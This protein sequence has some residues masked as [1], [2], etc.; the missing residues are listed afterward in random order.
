MMQKKK[1]KEYVTR[2]ARQGQERNITQDVP[3]LRNGHLYIK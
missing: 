2:H 1:K 3:I